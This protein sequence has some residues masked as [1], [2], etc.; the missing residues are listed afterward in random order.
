MRLGGHPGWFLAGQYGKFL[1]GAPALEI[2][3]YQCQSIL[4]TD[5][6]SLY[7]LSLSG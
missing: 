7:Q 4:L 5:K 1:L 6:L 2:E 3:Y